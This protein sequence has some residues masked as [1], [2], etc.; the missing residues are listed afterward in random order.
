[1]KDFLGKKL[2]VV[3]GTSGIGLET[4]KLILERGGAAIVT[5]SK[6]VKL[7][8]ALAEL[9]KYGEVDGFTVDITNAEQLEALLNAIDSKYADV[10][11]LVNAAGVFSPKAFVSYGSRLRPI[12]G[13]EQGYVF[14]HSTFGQEHDCQE[15]KWRNR[16]HRV[17]VGKTSDS[18]DSVLCLLNGEGRTPFADA[19]SCNGTGSVQNLCQCCISC[20]G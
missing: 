13:S 6:G 19:A 3:G 1:M 9:T 15:T 14:H 4:A 8:E 20:G 16:Q 11:L 17:D 12:L 2:L 7:A 10:S 5:G 18:S